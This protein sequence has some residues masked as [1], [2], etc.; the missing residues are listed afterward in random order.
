LGLVFLALVLVQTGVDRIEIR[1]SS[2]QT[3]FHL[4]RGKFALI[5]SNEPSPPGTDWR[6]GWNPFSVN[7]PELY[8]HPKTTEFNLLGLQYV[9]G[10]RVQ[11]SFTG[12]AVGISYWYGVAI[13]ALVFWRTRRYLRRT[14]I[15]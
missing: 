10:T 2:G 4:G 8:F 6:S 14:A 11:T 9:A 1:G 15:S 13:A 3:W 7:E 12:W 5:A